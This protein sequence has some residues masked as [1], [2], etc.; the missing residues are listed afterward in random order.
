MS[1][2]N[3]C[4]RTRPYHYEALKVVPFVE[5]SPFVF[6]APLVAA[7]VPERCSRLR[8][9]KLC[10]H[11]FNGIPPWNLQ[12]RGIA[13]GG[14]VFKGIFVSLAC[15]GLKTRLRLEALGPKP[16]KLRCTRVKGKIF[17]RTQCTMRT[18]LREGQKGLVWDVEVNHI[19]KG[20]LHWM[21][22]KNQRKLQ[23][24]VFSGGI[25]TSH[26]SYGW[27]EAK[28][29]LL[30]RKTLSWSLYTRFSE[31]FPDTTVLL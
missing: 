17:E 26:G 1:A 9:K 22:K 24:R 19:L 13:Q 15:E 29:H 12:K 25:S 2:N 5:P 8:P 14:G 3:A 16:R 23:S 31:F 11:S 28:K 6:A 4:T 30:G 27:Q 7:N 10:L 18:V 20:G 21:K